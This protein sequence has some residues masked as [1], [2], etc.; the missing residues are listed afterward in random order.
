MFDFF[1]DVYLEMQGIDSAEAEKERKEKKREK[2]ADR[3]LLPK[4]I[5]VTVYVMG[6]VFLI[7]QATQI[8]FTAAKGITSCFITAGLCALAVA[9]MVLISIRKKQTEIVGTVLVVL[10]IFLMYLFVL[11]ESSALL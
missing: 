7:L 1:R 2:N 9:A 3:I 4:S 10:F 8:K 11:L 6:V 5:K